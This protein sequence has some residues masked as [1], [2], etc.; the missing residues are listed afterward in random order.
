MRPFPGRGLACVLVII[1]LLWLPGGG[2]PA[3]GGQGETNLVV[4]AS[5][6]G[7]I[8]TSAIAYGLWRNRPSQQGEKGPGWFPGEFYVGGYLGGSLVQNT[9]LKYL[10]G[11][12]PAGGGRLT[13]SRQKFEPAVVGGLKI[14]YFLQ[15]IRYL[16]FEIETN[17]SRSAVRDQSVTLS[18]PV[19]G[20]TRATVLNDRWVNWTMALHIVGRYG[21]L[22]DQEA[23]FGRLQPYVG[24]GPGLVVLYDDVDAAKNFALDLM[25]GVR[26]MMLKNVSAFVEYKFSHQWDVELES[27]SFIAANGILQRGAA[28]FDYTSHRIVLG[29]AYHF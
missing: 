10:G 14:G 6:L 16:G 28:T 8:G 26:Y 27:H 3:L 24:I 15:S 18:R 19:N 25:A 2:A 9:D 4:G 17:Y 1:G 5:V 22:P 20:S 7:V 12:V 29:V 21:F 11:I 23:P 13:T